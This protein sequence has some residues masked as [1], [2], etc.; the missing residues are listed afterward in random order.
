MKDVDEEHVLIRR[1]LLGELEEELR[2]QLEQ[3]VIS[4]SN[5]KQEVLITEGELLD[6]FV[7]GEL[8]PHDRALFLR[9]FLASPAQRRKLET[10]KALHAYAVNHKSP[11]TP[12]VVE[13]GWLKS[14]FALFS[15]RRRFLQFAWATVIL[16]AVLG[17][18]LLIYS[19]ISSQRP[20]YYDELVML[21]QPSSPVLEPGSSVASAQLS[22]LLFRGNSDAK[23]ISVTPE[24]D[25]L[26]LLLPTAAGTPAKYRVT[27]KENGGAQVFEL[28]DVST[29]Q[30][31]ANSILVLQIPVKMLTANEYVVETVENSSSADSVTV[32]PFRIQRSK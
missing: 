28:P 9:N 11:D 27:L 29:R 13:G 24:T 22:P 18:V 20:S 15:S 17:S 5:Y 19:I 26:Q 6:E 14:L 32:Y 21:N 7:S 30:V 16:L 8:S 23:T 4:D 25:K 3:R 1:Y 10:A 12:A 31:G 2:E